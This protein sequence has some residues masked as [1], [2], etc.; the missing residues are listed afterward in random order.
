[1]KFVKKKILEFLRQIQRVSVGDSFGSVTTLLTHNLTTESRM[2]GQFMDFFNTIKQEI[3]LLSSAE[4]DFTN[5]VV[6]METKKCFYGL[7]CFKGSVPSKGNLFF[8]C[9]NEL[10]SMIVRV[11]L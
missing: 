5:P 4:L 7:H 10:M 2:G 8:P 9:F 3:K 6:T 1:M 11:S